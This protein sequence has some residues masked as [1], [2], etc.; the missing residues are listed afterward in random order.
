MA[1]V[2]WLTRRSGKGGAL[3]LANEDAEGKAAECEL[4]RNPDNDGIILSQAPKL[5][6]EHLFNRSQNF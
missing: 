2:P 5:V 6:R 1:Q 3:Y 4:N